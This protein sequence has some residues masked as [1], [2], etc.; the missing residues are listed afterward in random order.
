M[1]PEKV[2]RLKKTF[3]KYDL[4]GNGT[5]DVHEIYANVR[6]LGKNYLPCLPSCQNEKGNT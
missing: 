1:P 4:N 3:Y 6:I 2:L 5:I